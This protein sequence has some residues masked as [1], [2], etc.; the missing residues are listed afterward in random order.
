MLT[1]DRVAIWLWTYLL[2]TRMYTVHLNTPIRTHWHKYTHIKHTHTHIQ[3]T[4]IHTHTH[5]HTHTHTYR[6][7]QHTH[8]HNLTTKDILSVV[9]WMNRITWFALL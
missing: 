2:H 6:H 7:I 8:T 4:H 5:S 9:P 1:V 3:H